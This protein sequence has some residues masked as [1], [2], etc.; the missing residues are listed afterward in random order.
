M[1]VVCRCLLLYV[2]LYGVRRYGSR[3]GAVR[4]Q[5]RQ[6]YRQ[7]DGHGRAGQ[8]RR[9][10]AYVR[11]RRPSGHGHDKRRTVRARRCTR[12]AGGR[13]GAMLLAAMRAT[14]TVRVAHGDGVALAAGGAMT[15]MM[16]MMV[17]MTSGRRRWRAG[18]G[19]GRLG[20]RQR[21]TAIRQQQRRV[22]GVTM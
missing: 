3:S 4:R 5:V 17:M 15:T 16:T 6:V 14:T 21:A 9:R 2:R 18:V 22:S 20:C 7:Y 8:A 11:R 1:Y 13:A 12:S 10:T 19:R